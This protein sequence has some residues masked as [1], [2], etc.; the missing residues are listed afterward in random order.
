MIKPTIE[1]IECKHTNASY[2]YNDNWYGIPP[3]ISVTANMIMD[4]EFN[5]NCTNEVIQ[6]EH[7]DVYDKYYIEEIVPYGN[8]IVY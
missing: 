8:G 5:I 1:E 3:C 6:G 2:G 4:F 7:I